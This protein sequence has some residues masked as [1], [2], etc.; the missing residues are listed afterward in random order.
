VAT[1]GFQANSS[2]KFG[3]RMDGR[4]PSRGINISH[5]GK[6]KIIFKMP[7]LGDM[8]VPWRVDDDR[9]MDGWMMD[10][11]VMYMCCKGDVFEGSFLGISS[12]GWMESD[13]SPICKNPIPMK[14]FHSHSHSSSMV[15][16]NPRFGRD[17]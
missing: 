1:R 2:W 7:F 16:Q 10:R 14:R 6:R 11:R 15:Q 17:A 13:R 12:K 3:T 5:L 9:W 4:I 8:L